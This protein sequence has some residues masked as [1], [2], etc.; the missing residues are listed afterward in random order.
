MGEK[1]D[2]IK[3]IT[4][5]LNFII[6]I[7]TIGIIIAAVYVIVTDEKIGKS[8]DEN[9]KYLARIGEVYELLQE[10]YYGDIDYDDVTEK[11]IEG[12]MQAVD[13]IYTRYVDE[14]EFSEMVEGVE[15]EYTGLGIH[16]SY[17]QKTRWYNYK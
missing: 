5:V 4:N 10:K 16:I 13:D 11:A 15:Q 1:K 7:A 14:E 17:D 9:E 2:K 6:T 8:K 12:M 3:I